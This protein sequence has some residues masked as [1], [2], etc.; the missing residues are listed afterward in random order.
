[1][2]FSEPQTLKEYLD[3]YEKFGFSEFQIIEMYI[4]DKNLETEFSNLAIKLTA[5]NLEKEKIRHSMAMSVMEAVPMKHLDSYTEEENLFLDTL[6]KN[7][8][9]SPETCLSYYEK[10]I[11]EKIPNMLLPSCCYVDVIA[12][13]N[14]KY[15]VR[16]KN[17]EQDMYF[18]NDWYK[19]LCDKSEGKGI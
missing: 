4:T 6:T 8:A 1:M 7:L 13:I 12:I 9:F 15:K 3:T 2:D 17:Q 19:A 5:K 11:R 14:Y 16:F 18:I 10:Q